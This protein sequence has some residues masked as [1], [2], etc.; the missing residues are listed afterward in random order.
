M[1]LLHSDGRTLEVRPIGDVVFSLASRRVPIKLNGFL[2]L[3]DAQE[4]GK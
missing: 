2:V 4:G 1:M 3:E